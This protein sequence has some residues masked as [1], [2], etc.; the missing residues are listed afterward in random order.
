[1]GVVGHATTI[2]VHPRPFGSQSF[3]LL[4]LPQLLLVLLFSANYVNSQP[5]FRKHVCPQQFGDDNLS[6]P[7]GKDSFIQMKIPLP[8]HTHANFMSIIIKFV[9]AIHILSALRFEV[10]RI[11]LA[12]TSVLAFLDMRFDAP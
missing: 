7:L 5:T 9:T 2:P 3:F 1:L 10:Y 11:L 12:F 4:S 8:W 6:P